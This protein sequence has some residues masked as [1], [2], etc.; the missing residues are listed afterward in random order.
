MSQ[1]TQNSVVRT[2]AVHHSLDLMGPERFC[3]SGL[4]LDGQSFWVRLE[5]TKVSDGPLTP[6]QPQ[7]ALAGMTGSLPGV[8]AS[9][10]PAQ[11]HSNE[12]ALF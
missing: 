1:T 9:R 7:V 10:T 6:S 8:P 5:L 12:Q 3:C 4:E 2:V 11:A